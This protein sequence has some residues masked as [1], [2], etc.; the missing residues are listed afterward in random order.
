[1]I[2][3]EFWR[4][5]APL[6]AGALAL[7]LIAAYWQH[8][9]LPGAERAFPVAEVRVPVWHLIWMG[10]WTGYT[11]A[12]VGEAAGIFALPYSMSILQFVNASVTPSTQLL[13]FLNPFG[14]L[15]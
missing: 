8:G 13:T 6:I 14:A 15:L 1:M 12:V 11:M 2:A 5:Q 3:R 4:Q 7:G 9:F 10:M